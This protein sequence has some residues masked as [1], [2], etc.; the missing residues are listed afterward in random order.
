MNEEMQFD[1]VRHVIWVV[2]HTL[3]RFERATWKQYQ[4][5]I[6]H[7]ILCLQL[8]DDWQMYQETTVNLMIRV[9]AYLHEI[10]SYTRAE[11]ICRRALQLAQTIVEPEHLLVIRATIMWRCYTNAGG[12]YEQAECIISRPSQP[13]RGVQSQHAYDREYLERPRTSLHVT[14]EVRAGGVSREAS[15]ICPVVYRCSR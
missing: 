6:S 12:D 1:W 5:Y 8:I 9:G 10:A 11:P 7:A 2:A 3:P 13:A 14:R 4:R 15:A